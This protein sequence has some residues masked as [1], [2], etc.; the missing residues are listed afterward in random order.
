MLKVL[1][2]DDEQR[3]INLIQALVDFE[4]LG[5][6]VVGTAAN[7]I[8][9]IEQVK[10]L[11]PDILITDIRMPGCDGLELIKMIK[12]EKNSPEV[13]IISGYTNFEYA[14]TAIKFGVCDYLLKPIN[15]KELH[16]IL[17]K[18]KLKIEE[19]NAKNAQIENIIKENQTIK[20]TDSFIR[21]L[22][23]GVSDLS[24][25]S[26][27]NEYNFN[28]K[29]GLFQVFMLKID[30]ESDKVNLESKMI[31]VDKI[32]GVLTSGLKQLCHDFAF[33]VIDRD[34]YGILNY[35]AKKQDDVKRVLKDCLNQLIILKQILGPV[36]CTISLSPPVKSADDIC[37]SLSE[38][39]F[40]IH[41]RLIYGTEKLLEVQPIEKESRSNYDIEK[42]TRNITNTIESLSQ[43]DALNVTLELK[44]DILKLKNLSGYE[45]LEN[46]FLAGSSFI[47]QTNI[48]NQTEILSEFQR[49]CYQSGNVDK[50]FEKLIDLQ[51][52]IIDKI[53]RERENDTLRPIRTAKQYIQKRFSQP[54]T[55]EEVSEVVGLSSAYFSTLFKKEVGEGFAKYI[56]NVR[57]EQAKVLLRETNEPISKI[58]KDVGYQDVKH[59]N[60][61][62]EKITGVKPSVFRKLYG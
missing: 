52:R 23:A 40:Y 13:V 27:C 2:A 19:N 10:T 4:S 24:I 22:I 14:Q 53:L 54:I 50:I 36:A 9:A 11:K 38:A 20:D 43:D 45:I 56:I 17:I 33:A 21:S 61:T 7:G 37:D 39:I 28:A 15:Q 44:K 6:K 18:M 8:E 42:Y 58:C 49:R 59:F 32:Q 26:L 35:E 48:K 34:G 62:F 55:L 16:D 1:I 41:Q 29:E 60:Q 30:F 3:I 47:S 12:A 51:Q 57:M 5:L 46:V 25:E 31:V